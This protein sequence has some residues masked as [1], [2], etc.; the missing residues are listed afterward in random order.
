MAALSARMQRLVGRPFLITSPE[1]VA[2]VLY[3]D[4]GPPQLTATSHG[5]ASQR[6]AKN[7]RPSKHHST[8][9]NHLVR[10]KELHPVSR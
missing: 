2:Q 9:E 4:L 7:I 5:L 3:T 6:K 10:L 1:A 8:S